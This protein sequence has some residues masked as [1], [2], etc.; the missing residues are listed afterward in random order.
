MD[1]SKIYIVIAASMGAL[2]VLLGAFGAHKL[3]SFLLEANRLDTFETAVKYQ[4]YH[5]LALLVVGILLPT[6]PTKLMMWSGVSFIVGMVLFS[7]SLYLLCFT[8][9]RWLGPITPLGGLFLIAGWL[10]LAISFFNK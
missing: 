8:T 5:V 7:G 4:M 3:K 1:W 2:D 6:V 10:M 9:W